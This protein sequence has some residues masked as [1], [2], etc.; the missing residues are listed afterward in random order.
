MS[1]HISRRTFL[2]QAANV[3]VGTG[4]L[5]LAGCGSTQQQ[6][7]P[8]EAAE[9]G[10]TAPAK[11]AGAPVPA[12]L[13]S[14]DGE[15]EFFNRAIDLFES[16]HPDIKIS[17]VFVPGGDEY[18]T[19]LD[20]MIASGDPPA[21]YAP[22]STRGY[23]YYAARGLS[24][25][26]DEFVKADNLDL[27]DFHPDGMKGCRWE[28]KL[29]ALPLDLWPHVIYY[30]KTL[31]KE[32]G[33]P[34][35]TTD[36]NDASWTTDQYLD[37]ARKLTKS[38]GDQVTQF[39]SDVYFDYWASGWTFGGDWFPLDTYETGI[40]ADL[41]G[42]K[43]ERVTNA[44]QW[45]ADLML[46][47]KVAPTPALAQQVQAGAPQLFM[48]NK[49]GMGI[50]NIGRLSQYAKITD[51]EWGVA[52]APNPPGGEKRH[53]HVWIDFWSMIKGVKNLEGSWEFLKFMVSSEAQKIYPIEYGPQSSLL[54]LGSYWLDIQKKQLPNL[55]DAELK[56]LTEAP[57]YE[58]IDPENWTVNFSVINAQ[59]LQ[60]ALDVV[61]LGEKTAAE[62]IAEVAPNIRKLIDETK[63]IE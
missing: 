43:D 27:S 11:E 38:E 26:L 61:W 4:V 19:K 58:Q 53:L 13:R 54:S 37:I 20:L 15:E 12:L 39:G 22:F 36:W 35:L 23:R 41:T 44:V 33:I 1:I 55:S 3:A 47:E 34:D 25:E 63:V 30:N 14:G 21:I 8:T 7:A 31:F 6:A 17:R 18:I 62:S 57:K 32:A 45:A 49:I 46:K 59:V 52:A 42:D 28:G 16:Q 29:M 56:A 48:S 40:V 10:A 50:N 2:K 51:F 5:W 60:P 24:Q 9:V